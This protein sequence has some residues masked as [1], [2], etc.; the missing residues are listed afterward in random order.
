MHGVDPDADLQDLKISQDASDQRDQSTLK[1]VFIRR[2][3]RRG[4]W[5]TSGASAGHAG[6]QRLHPCCG[7]GDDDAQERQA[8]GECSGKGQMGIATE[9]ALDEGV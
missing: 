6:E 8:R 4:L 5:W 2:S 3:V 7:D 9:T 1:H